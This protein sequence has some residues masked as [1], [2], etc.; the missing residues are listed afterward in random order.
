MSINEQ[1]RIKI[2]AGLLV[3]SNYDFKMNLPEDIIMLF[4]LFKKHNKKLYIVGGAVRDALLGKIPKDID[5]VT[6]ALPNEVENLL[7]AENIYNFPSGKNFG[8]ISAVINDET[9][10]IATFR[11]D[12]YTDSADGRR[13]DSITFA[14]M[15]DDAK[16]RDFT[17]NALYYD[18]DEKKVIDLVGGVEDLKNKKIKP[19]GNAHDRF[20]EDRLRTLRALRFAHRFGSTLDKETIDA[21]IHFKDLPGVSS[22]RIRD[23]FI[24]SLHSSQKPEEFLEQFLKLG[25]GPRVFGNIKLDTRH[26]SELRHPVLVLAKLLWNNDVI[27]I[28]NSLINFKTPKNEIDGV[29]FLKNIHDRFKDFDKLTFDPIIDGKW[30]MIL[31][32]NKNLLF[33]N[34]VLTKYE[35]LL[36]SKIMN[37][38]LNVINAFINY[39][40]TVTALNFPDIAPGKEL[41]EK[42]ILGN[43]NNFIK[44]F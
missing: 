38:P 12:N 17:I 35:I 21:I 27:S 40:P 3:E 20:T 2:N 11:S 37:L 6:D 32:K 28:Q 26:V 24:K 41:G 23:E 36:W 4:T 16:R 31:I 5:V 13:P 18:I 29:L 7:T 30:L 14:S 43:A 39:V 8:I 22:E 10:E 1:K 34:N 44:S 19:V 9:Y 25:L 15:E 33:Q 42:I